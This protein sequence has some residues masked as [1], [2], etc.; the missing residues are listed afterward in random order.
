MFNIMFNMKSITALNYNIKFLE[1]LKKI[2]SVSDYTIDKLAADINNMTSTIFNTWKKHG[3][4]IGIQELNPDC[5]SI[6]MYTDARSTNQKDHIDVNG[7]YHSYDLEE[8]LKRKVKIINL[9]PVNEY[10]H[11]PYFDTYYRTRDGVLKPP[12]IPLPQTGINTFS[13][14]SPTKNIYENVSK[15]PPTII[16]PLLQSTPTT[17]NSNY[18]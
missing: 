11:Y 7:V 16:N 4:Y 17:I 6:S 14:L 18:N 9:I 8:I 15:L 12:P 2:P 1:N 10:I 3:F 5:D 13:L